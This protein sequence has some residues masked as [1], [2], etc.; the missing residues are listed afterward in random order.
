MP[1]LTIDPFLIRCEIF[2]EPVPSELD[3]GQLDFLEDNHQV[4]RDDWSVQDQVVSKEHVLQH[5][6]VAWRAICLPV[7]LRNIVIELPRKV[8]KGHCV[9]DGS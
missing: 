3:F 1:T 2:L 4:D 8:T 7:V 5:I 6:E 9:R